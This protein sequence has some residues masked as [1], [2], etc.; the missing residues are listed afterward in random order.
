MRGACSARHPCNCLV[1]FCVLTT[2]LNGVLGLKAMLLCD[3]ARQCCAELKRE[4][5]PLERTEYIVIAL[6]HCNLRTLLRAANLY[7]AKPSHRIYHRY[8]ATAVPDHLLGLCLSLA[9]ERLSSIQRIKFYSTWL[10]LPARKHVKPLSLEGCKIFS[11]ALKP[12]VTLVHRQQCT[13][14]WRSFLIHAAE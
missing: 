1:C 2:L 11:L 5:H 6:T 4:L 9:S 14:I 12:I 8:N 7:F 10:I 13:W 3:I